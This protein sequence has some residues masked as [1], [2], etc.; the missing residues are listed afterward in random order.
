MDRILLP[1]PP[2]LPHFR[3][4]KNVGQEGGKW[5]RSNKENKAGDLFLRNK[6]G[7]IISQSSGY[8]FIHLG[9]SLQYVFGS[10]GLGMQDGLCATRQLKHSAARQIDYLVH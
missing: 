4:I 5:G 10:D 7:T 9:S 3:P 1:A 6:G 2:S 8:K